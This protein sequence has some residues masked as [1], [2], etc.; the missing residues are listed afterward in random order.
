MQKGVLLVLLLLF[1][2][3]CEKDYLD[4]N[5]DPNNPVTASES[6]LLPAAQVAYAFAFSG[7]YDRVAG[8]FV[9]H[10][11]NRRF[12]QY[13]INPTETGLVNSWQFDIFGGALRDLDIIIKQGTT[14]ENWHYVGIAKL[15]KAYI[16]SMMVDLFGDLPYTD[17]LTGGLGGSLYPVY[18]DDAE[19]YEKLLLLVDEG[20]ED[21]GKTSK[22]SPSTNDLI[23]PSNNWVTSSLP[24]WVRMG[25]SLKLKLYNQTRLTNPDRARTKINE[26]IAAKSYITAINEDFQFAF[27]TSD[28]PDNRHPNYQADYENS[29]RENYMSN[30]FYVLLDTLTDPRI[31]YYFTNQ[32]TSFQGRIPGSAATAGNDVNS[33]TVFGLFPVGGRFS[34]TGAVNQNS[35]RGDAPYRMITSYIVQFI[36]A[37]A[38]LTLNN[39]PVAAK[40]AFEAGTRQSLAKVNAFATGLPQI[41][42]TGTGSIDEYVTSQLKVFDRASN[43]LESVITQKYIAQ[44]GNSVE[45]YTD[46]RRTGF[47]AIGTIPDPLGVFPLRLPYDPDEFQGPNPPTRLLQNVPV[48][49][50]IN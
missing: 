25:N 33:R 35:A 27:G 2:S 49:W 23:Y 19:V 4:I 45:S 40:V 32:S 24:K 6:Q 11:V 5:N 18:E 17:A 43:K 10:Y 37:E 30:T 31:P 46:F 48:F 8:S 21:L 7:N 9:K 38:Q 14:N 36:I 42:A 16:Y 28:S 12:D 1:L 22:A 47:P 26:L 20:I 50:D 34:G 15:Q 13:S 3:A 41:P 39:D 29:S 44:F